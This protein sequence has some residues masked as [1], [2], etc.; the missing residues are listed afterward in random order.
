ML[1]AGCYTTVCDNVFQYYFKIWFLFGLRAY[2]FFCP[3]DMLLH[4]ITH[5]TI[6]LLRVV[7]CYYIT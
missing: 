5:V 2:D 3:K 7:T 4:A 1:K 6:M